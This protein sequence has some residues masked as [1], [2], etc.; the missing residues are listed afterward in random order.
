MR[1]EQYYQRS[2]VIHSTILETTTAGKLN[3]TTTTLITSI[4]NRNFP[5]VFNE[6]V[7]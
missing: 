4:L 3:E 7:S 6:N 5:V 1:T 2:F